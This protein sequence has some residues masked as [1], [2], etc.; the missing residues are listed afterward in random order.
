MDMEPLWAA[1]P[2]RHGWILKYLLGTMMLSVVLG[3][4]VP[5]R[6]CGEVPWLLKGE[7]KM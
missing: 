6:S 1:L 2:E 3:G 7:N 5:P 4:P